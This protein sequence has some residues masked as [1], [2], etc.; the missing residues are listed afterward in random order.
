MFVSKSRSSC[1]I[2]L[3]RNDISLDEFDSRESVC[4]SANDGLPFIG[5]KRDADDRCLLLSS[6]SVAHR[7]TIR[8]SRQMAS[9]MRLHYSRT[10]EKV[11]HHFVSMF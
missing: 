10:P 2:A 1:V 6:F 11:T 5:S 7:L 3:D 8:S 4:W 9:P